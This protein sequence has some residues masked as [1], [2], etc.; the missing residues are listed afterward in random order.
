MNRNTGRKKIRRR[1][2]RRNIKPLLIILLLL[3]VLI[4]VLTK[5]VFVVRSVDVLGN[6][7]PVSQ[8]SVVRAASIKFGRSIFRVDEDEI[9]RNIT[10]MGTIYPESVQ[11]NYPDTVQIRVMP[12]NRVAML[13]HM[14]KV[15]V[16][17][18][19]GCVVESLDTVPDMDLVYLSSMSVQGCEAGK[20][21]RADAGQLEAYC[22]VAAAL[23]HHN[24]G[25]YV[26]E[27]DLSDVEKLTLITR[28][29]ITVELGD[30]GRMND[31]IAWMKSAVADLQSRG[32]TGG[33]LDVSS[34][35]KAD[36]RYPEIIQP[37]YK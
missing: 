24:A 23:L 20:Q 18:E 3:A 4:F 7:G 36:Y 15:R 16:L 5:F 26:S 29:G 25:S 35:T 9:M 1:R 22:A 8:E 32:E 31:K 33:T 30:T 19:H 28:S 34:A 13:L 6:T 21:I 2:R 12:R 37:V 14:G 27:L 10:G 17:D 11:L